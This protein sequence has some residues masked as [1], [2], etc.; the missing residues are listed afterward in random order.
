MASILEKKLCKDE[1]GYNNNVN[2]FILLFCIFAEYNKE[3]CFF[4]RKDGYTGSSSYDESLTLTGSQY[5]PDT[6]RTRCLDIAD[7]EA[8]MYCT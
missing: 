2:N 4:D 1:Y 8:V 3:Q 6:C 7:C 5:T